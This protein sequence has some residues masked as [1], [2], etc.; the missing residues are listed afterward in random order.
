M[1]ARKKSSSSSV[2][3]STAFQPE[4]VIKV[5]RLAKHRYAASAFDGE[6]ARLFGARWNSPGTAV[7]YASSTIALAVLEVLVH[8]KSSGILSSY[9]LVE[10]EFDERLVEELL[11]SALPSN[12]DTS[13]PPT[14]AQALGDAWVFG[15]SAVV[16]RVPSVVIKS[17][18]NYLINPYHRDFTNV[19]VGKPEPFSF[20]SRLIT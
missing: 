16:L 19:R 18:W 1:W 12:W 8:V 17:E 5:W 13:P 6:G 4:L 9:A 2:A 10:A 15:G 11:P 20:D 3:S 14:A 7:A